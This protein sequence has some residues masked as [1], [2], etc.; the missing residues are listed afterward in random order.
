MRRTASKSFVAGCALL[1]ATL[2]PVSLA[3]AQTTNQNGTKQNG[4]KQ[5]VTPQATPE[6]DTV[7]LF[8]TGVLSIASVALLRHRAKRKS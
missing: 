5:N 2:G 6:I 3:H 4:T 7:V 8:G 1:L